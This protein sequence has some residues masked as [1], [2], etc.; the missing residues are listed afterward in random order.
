MIRSLSMIVAWFEVPACDV[1]RIMCLIKSSWFFDTTPHSKQGNSESKYF[2]CGWVNVYCCVTGWIVAVDWLIL[3]G[4][5]CTYWCSVDGVN[6]NRIWWDW[7]RWVRNVSVFAKISLH[8]EQEYWIWGIIVVTVWGA[9]WIEICE[10]VVGV[11][12]CTFDVSD[13]NGWSKNEQ[14]LANASNHH[15]I[16]TWM[17][18]NRLKR[19]M[20]V[21]ESDCVRMRM[22]VLSISVLHRQHQSHFVVILLRYMEIW[23]MRLSLMMLLRRDNLARHQISSLINFHRRL[24]I[25]R[26]SL[27]ILTL[28]AFGLRS[29]LRMML[30]YNTAHY[31]LMRLLVWIDDFIFNVDFNCWN[32]RFR[33]HF[34]LNKNLPTIRFH[35]LDLI[36]QKV[37][38]LHAFDERQRF[39]IS[40][41][42]YTARHLLGVAYRLAFTIS[43]CAMRSVDAVLRFRLVN[44]ILFQKRVRI[45]TD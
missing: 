14:C 6:G 31:N 21:T 33:R 27:I 30:L 17:D 40:T 10:D 29:R 45:S 26:L 38:V 43:F 39:L 2:L 1:C 20:L 15:D 3:V 7:K 19:V 4:G 42:L 18:L 5:N 23:L 13:G 32:E 28:L 22:I 37:E 35:V 12:W 41:L 25:H 9:V 24:T 36:H 16:L 34:I 8:E 11:W 44:L